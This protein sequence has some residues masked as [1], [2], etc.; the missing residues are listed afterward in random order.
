MAGIGLE[1]AALLGS[2]FRA[3]LGSCHSTLVTEYCVGNPAERGEVDMKRL[4]A[5]KQRDGSLFQAIPKYI[6]PLCFDNKEEAK[7]RR[8]E[9]NALYGEGF[10]HVTPGPDHHNYRGE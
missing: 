10:V 6:G 3:V 4:F 5:L 2:A 1:G 8:D 7:A 9:V